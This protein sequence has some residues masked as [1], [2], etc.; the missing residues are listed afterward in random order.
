M[1]KWILF[2]T[3]LLAA[4][5]STSQAMSFLDKEHSDK[6]AKEAK[7]QQKIAKKYAS[8]SRVKES[9]DANAGLSA[10]QLFLSPI[11]PGGSYLMTI[12]PMNLYRSVRGLRM[13][14]SQKQIEQ[15]KLLEKYVD[16]LV[17]DDE[18]IHALNSDPRPD[19]DYKVKLKALKASKRENYK[20][21]CLRQ[22]ASD[23]ARP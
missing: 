14:P 21:A 13:S 7:K 12:N 10:Y 15:M 18:D 9:T 17:A 20:A 22:Y 4:T 16:L 2:L 3:L 5:P 11:Q 8:T 6:L 23:Y 1:M 19:K